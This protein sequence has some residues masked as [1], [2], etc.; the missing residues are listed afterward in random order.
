MAIRNMLIAIAAALA[1]CNGAQAACPSLSAS[2][3]PASCAAKDKATVC[4]ACIDELFAV[5]QGKLGCVRAALRCRQATARMP[6]H[7]LF[8]QSHGRLQPELWQL[9]Q[10][11]GARV[12]WGSRQCERAAELQHRRDGGPAAAPPAVCGQQ[13]DRGSAV[14]PAARPRPLGIA[15]MYMPSAV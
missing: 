14:Q 10:R 11:R 2:D 5:V 6:D 4:G 13:A 1:T 3:V 15:Q 7:S 12:H 9:H 8:A